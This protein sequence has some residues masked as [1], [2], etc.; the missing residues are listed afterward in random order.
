[1]S[2]TTNYVYCRRKN[3][4]RSV[5]P[6]S[7][8]GNIHTSNNRTIEKLPSVVKQLAWFVRQPVETD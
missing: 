5:F 2:A 8:N 3:C 1:M 6:A 7:G 4:P